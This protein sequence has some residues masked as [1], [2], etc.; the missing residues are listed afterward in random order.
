MKK[1]MIVTLITLLFCL[2][3]IVGVR[4]KAANET[5]L[6]SKVYTERC[7][8]IHWVANALR[9]LGFENGSEVQKAALKQCG[10]YWHEQNNLRKQA[11]AKEEAEKPKV[12]K[13]D[14]GTWTIT[15]YCNDGQSASGSPNVVGKTCAC[16]CLPFGSVIEIEGMGT[17]TVTDRGASSGQWAWHNSNWADIYLANN[18][19]CNNWGVQ[20]RHVY[21][22]G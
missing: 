7:E 21:L 15:A 22:V 6:S 17:W 14:L 12:T 1:H 4:A 3:C 18:S 20:K 5:L 19:E 9:S 13:Q 8:K 16:N 11:L 2:T 10:D